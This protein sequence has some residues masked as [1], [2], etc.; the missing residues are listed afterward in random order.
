M[1]YTV[2]KLAQLAGVSS[3]TLR[4][5]DEVGILKPARI[6]SSGYRIYGALEVERLQQILLYREL[7][8][9]LE[10]IKSIMLDPQFD[11]QSALA[12]HLAQL[13]KKKMRLELL[14]NNVEKTMAA[15]K[16]DETMTDKERFEGL[17][18]QQLADNEAKYGAEVR[19]KYGEAAVAASN[20]MYANMSF[21]EHAE[22]ERINDE[23]FVALKAGFA[24]GDAGSEAA[25]QAADLH[26]QWLQFFWPEYS[27]EAHRGI[28]QMYVD[29]ERFATFYDKEQPGLAEF[30]RD[31]VL[32]YTSK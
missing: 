2:Q 22:V 26:R 27:A 8:V 12:H 13:L 1:E 23:M 25:Q 21:E 4:Y 30:L 10:T 19:E 17:K 29:D 32:I 20:K 14:I 7:D 31:A 15:N 9:S 5:Y 3:R 11:M 28:T 24:T 6:N 18:Q 16:G